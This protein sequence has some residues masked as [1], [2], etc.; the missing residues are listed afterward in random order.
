MHDYKIKTRFKNGAV[1]DLGYQEIIE[2][3]KMGEELSHGR[4]FKDGGA[5]QVQE[6]MTVLKD[7]Y[8]D[9]PNP[10]ESMTAYYNGQ[11]ILAV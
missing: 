7:I 2:R 4:P 5:P 9:K 11:A 10:I 3:L 8:K 1:K 6:L